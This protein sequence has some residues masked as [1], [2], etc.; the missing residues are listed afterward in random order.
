MLGYAA[1]TAAVFLVAGL[2]PVAAQQ[3]DGMISFNNHCRTCHSV[4]QGDNRLGPALFGIFGAQAG[5]VRGYGGYSG[6]LRGFAWDETTLD[7]FIADPTAIS[8]GT[9]MVFPPVADAQERRRIIEF[10]KTVKAAD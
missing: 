6:G 5:Q 8:A 4:R 9:N 7:R 2:T 10:L 3:D 1:C